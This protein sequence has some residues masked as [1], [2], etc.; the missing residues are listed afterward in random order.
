MLVRHSRQMRL[1][2]GTRVF[3]PGSAPQSFLLLIEGTIRVH[4]MSENG[5]E[6]VLYRVVAGE[7]CALTTACL[8]GYEDYQAE[9]VGQRARF[10]S[11]GHQPPARRVPAPRLGAIGSRDDRIA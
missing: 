9:A 2:V 8:M 3:G 5:R 7:S 6:I 10:G 4:Q 11:R 1:P